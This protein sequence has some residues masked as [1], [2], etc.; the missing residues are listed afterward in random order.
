MALDQQKLNQLLEQ[1]LNDFGATFH[2]AMVQIG[3]K[4][5]LYKT[6]ATAGPSTSAELAQRTGTAERYVRE[7]LNCQAAES[8]GSHISSF[9]HG[10]RGA[11]LASA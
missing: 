4:L 9:C 2:A 1:G 8:R 6:L 11:P 10:C 7:W 3:D 5:G